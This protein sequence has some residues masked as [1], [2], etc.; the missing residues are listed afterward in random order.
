MFN[1]LIT[2]QQASSRNIPEDEQFTEKEEKS[3]YLKNI[4][5]MKIKTTLTCYLCIS[6]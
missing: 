6:N 2:N 3:I 4:L 5:N 1:I